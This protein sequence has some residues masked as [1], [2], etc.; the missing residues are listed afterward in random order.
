MSGKFQV[1]IS[2]LA[3]FAS[4]PN[5]YIQRKGGIRNQK[6]VNIGNA[7]HNNIG[8]KSFSLIP[9]VVIVIISLV[10]FYF[11]NT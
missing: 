8:S 6:A 2:K 4:N 5:D 11:W 3:D 7:G 10:G 1:P 9:I